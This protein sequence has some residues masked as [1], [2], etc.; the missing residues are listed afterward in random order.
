[1]NNGAMLNGSHAKDLP[2][3]ASDLTWHTTRVM[4]AATHLVTASCTN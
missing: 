2:G 1:M 4:K 3:N